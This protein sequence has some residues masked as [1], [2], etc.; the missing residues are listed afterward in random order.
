M[1]QKRISAPRTYNIKRKQSK[2]ITR[3]HPGPH[4]KNA[5][6]LSIV[7]KDMLQVA[8]ITKEAKKILNE[9]KVLVDGVIRKDHRFPVGFLDVVS[10]PLL[11]KSYRMIYDTNGRYTTCLLKKNESELKVVRIKGKARKGKKYQLSTNDGRTILVNLGTGKNYKVND[12]LLIKVPSQEI[13]KHLPFKANS[14]AFITGG[15]HVGKEAI[16][17]SES[18]SSVTIRIDGKEYRT[19]KDYVFVISDEVSVK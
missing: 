14:K 8:R 4:N 10:I 19:I 16:V 3:P 15:K 13:V 2:W 9:G 6:P 18:D 1:N 17:S 5:V 11:K 12:S 7:L